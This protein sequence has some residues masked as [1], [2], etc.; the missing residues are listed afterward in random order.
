M[1]A[2]ELTNLLDGDDNQPTFDQAKRSLEWP[3][4]EKAIQAKLAQLRVKGTWKLVE[5]PKNAIPIS[6]KWVL[7]KK[8]DKE[9]NIVKYKAHLV[10]RG[11]TQC[12]GLDYDE[13]FFPVIHFETI[14]ALLA[15]VPSKRLKVWQLD[16]KGAYL[17]GKLTQ[18]IFMEQ[19]I[20]FDDKSGLVC[21]L[22]KSIYSLK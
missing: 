4:W 8:Q 7:T 12:P 9:G 19:P 15:M 21:L 20:G 6:N 16:V 22:I 14:R 5:K 1:K 13:T 10:A 11:F 18:P 2:K 17:N 3:E